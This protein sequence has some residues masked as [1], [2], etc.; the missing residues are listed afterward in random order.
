MILCGICDCWQH[1]SCYGLLDEEDVPELHVCVK[2]ARE[3]SH[4]HVTQCNTVLL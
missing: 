2:C 3:V 1:A 4:H